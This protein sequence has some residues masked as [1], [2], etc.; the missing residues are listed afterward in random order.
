MK[1]VRIPKEIYITPRPLVKYTVT[2]PAIMN[3]NE[4]DLMKLTAQFVARNGKKF[5]SNLS[6]KE[7]N[8]AEFEFL[9]PVHPI[10][11]YF[12]KL[13]N[14]YCTCI[15][16][17]DKTLETVKSDTDLSTLVL[18]TFGAAEWMR[19]EEESREEKAADE[20]EERLQ[21]QLIDWHRFVVLET[22]DFDP[23]EVYPAP[24]RTIQEIN[25]ILSTENRGDIKVTLAED[26]RSDEEMDMDIDKSSGV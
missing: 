19:R 1:L 24:A 18:K 14:A 11:P 5:L 9:D 25:V 23:G 8:N 21:M 22:L 15:V 13:V 26:I 10:F 20:E 2:L 4:I 17:P 7:A 12:Q 16:P 6:S 3:S